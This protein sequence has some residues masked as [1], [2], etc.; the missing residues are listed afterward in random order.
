MSGPMRLGIHFIYEKEKVMKK[1]NMLEG[2]ILPSLTKLAI[3]IMATAM[4][5]MAYNLTDMAWIGRVGADAVTAVGSAGMYV[6]LSQ[7]VVALA[8]MGGQ[9]K[10][11]HSL[12]EKDEKEA[13]LYAQG[14]FQ[15]AIL[16]AAVYG[17]IA[18]MAAKPLIGFYGLSSPAII[19]DAEKYLRITCGCILFTFLSS[20]FTGV[21]T[22]SGDS[23]T[24]FVA[25]SVGL[26]ANMILD[27]VLIFGIGPIPAMGAVG[28]ALATVSAQ[29]IVVF[30]FLAAVKK[31]TLLF[32]KIHILKKTPW[33]H[34]RVMIQIGLPSSIQNLIY[35][36]ISMALTRMVAG[37]GDTAVAVQRVGSQIESISYLTAE[38]FAAAVNSFIGQNYGSRQMK[39]VKK[40]YLTAVGTMIL[41]GCFTSAVLIFVP[42]PIFG[43]FIKDA[44]ILPDGIQYLRILGYSQLLMCIEI[45]T[46]GAFSGL[47]KTIQPAIISIL[48]T[49][50][51]IPLA[52]LLSST[53]LGLDGIWWAF[54]LSSIAKGIIFFVSFMIFIK[55]MMKKTEREQ[56]RV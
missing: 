43:L 40:G 14:A 3:P 7:G 5:Q 35:T 53:T 51:R 8:R 23:K 49:S 26:I 21:L 31:D 42:G 29:I 54:S 20:I 52:I 16:F 38:G 41:W 12:G 46:V 55:F 45:T 30:V 50:A 28:A 39:R 37:F 44:S 15:I 11:A 4:V 24:P 6:W 2:P 17:L 22:A 34:I 47:G 32:D 48:L 36:S 33:S 13:A 9:V 18:V 27:P 25:N 19:A 10:V 1:I 56:S